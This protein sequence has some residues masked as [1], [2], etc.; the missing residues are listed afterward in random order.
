M[1]A[2]VDAS[3]FQ[4]YFGGPERCPLIQVEGR[5]FPVAS[6]FLDDLLWATGHI[7]EDG[8][9]YS[10]SA[11]HH[12]YHRDAPESRDGQ[13]VCDMFLL[14]LYRFGCLLRLTVDLF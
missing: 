7:I 1:S 11:T 12:H 3:L 6:Y 5:A 2:T 9:K 14:C 4:N 10:T 13:Q 8:S